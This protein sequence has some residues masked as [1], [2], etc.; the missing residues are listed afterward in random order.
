MA[1]YI[2]EVLRF[3]V[4]LSDTPDR[5]RTADR[6]LAAQLQQQKVPIELIRAAFVLGAARRADRPHPGPP[7]P[8]IRSLHYFLPIIEEIRH[9]SD[10]GYLLYLERRAARPSP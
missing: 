6:I 7:L 3:Y 9:D 2:D 8:P 4:Q 5:A 1:A 10:P